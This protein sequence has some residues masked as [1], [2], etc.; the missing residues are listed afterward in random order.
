MPFM[1]ALRQLD[2]TEFVVTARLLGGV[3]EAAM[4]AVESG[5]DLATVS[6]R[7]VELVRAAL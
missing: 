2:V 6:E 4:A 1:V 3:I 5:S 7:T